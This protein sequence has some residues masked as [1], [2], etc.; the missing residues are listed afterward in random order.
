MTASCAHLLIAPYN[1]AFR[2]IFNCE[3]L[4]LAMHHAPAGEAKVEL[5]YILL[6]NSTA[7]GLGHRRAGTRLKYGFQRAV[8]MADEERREAGFWQLQT[9]WQS[10]LLMLFFDHEIDTV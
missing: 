3:A 4:L 2:C 7:K 9:C 10:V 6:M 5:V 1:Q 8:Q